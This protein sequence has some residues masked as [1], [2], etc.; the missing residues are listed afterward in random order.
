MYLRIRLKK[1][2]SALISDPTLLL[3]LSQE[4]QSRRKHHER[5]WAQIHEEIW[6]NTIW[7]LQRQCLQTSTQT[8]QRF[9]G[10]RNA[11][12]QKRT[13]KQREKTTR[14]NQPYF[15]PYIQNQWYSWKPPKEMTTSSHRSST[16]QNKSATTSTWWSQISPKTCRT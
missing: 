4:H 6:R 2:P 9:Q 12:L 14:S 3:P 13:I 16:T 5:E 8:L 7:L 11:I 10:S 15:P 1:V